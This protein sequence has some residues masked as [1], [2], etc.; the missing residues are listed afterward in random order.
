MRPK[1]NITFLTYSLNN[2][3]TLFLKSKFWW[4]F[5]LP[6]R[7]TLKPF[8]IQLNDS[9]LLFPLYFWSLTCK[10][11]SYLAVWVHFIYSL[12]ILSPLARHLF[13][14]TYAA[15][16]VCTVESSCA[17]IRTHKTLLHANKSQPVSTRMNIHTQMYTLCAQ[18][19]FKLAQSWSDNSNIDDF[20]NALFVIINIF[21]TTKGERYFYIHI[22]I[23]KK[24][25]QCTRY[26]PK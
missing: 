9:C 21:K 10:D 19:S 13:M 23:L 12:E 11:L 18:R 7:P 22:R 3:P 17:D 14:S 16:S 2:C 25:G 24:Y 5:H 4:Y 15:Q 26:F 6:V 20:L 1:Y 8:C